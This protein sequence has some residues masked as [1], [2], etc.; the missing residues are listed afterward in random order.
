MPESDAPRIFTVEE[1]TQQ[2][3][4]ITDLIRQLQ[5]VHQSIAKTNQ[6]LDEKVEKLSAGNGYPIKELREQVEELTEHQLHLVQAF[7]SAAEQL[8]EIG[9]VLKD[10]AQGL[11]DFYA[12]RDGELVFLCW[13]VGERQ[14]R[15]WHS[16][17]DGF[18]GR[19]PL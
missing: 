1:A 12:M 17:E 13:R 15:F 5:G 8:E 9:C 14:I 19:Q 10:L 7:Q 3:G 2:L 16:V 11:V 6:Q 18:S 4:Q